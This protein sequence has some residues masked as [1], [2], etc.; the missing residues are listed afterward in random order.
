MM[1]AYQMVMPGERTRAHRHTPSALRLILDADP[2]AYTIVDGEKV[3]MLAGDVVLTPNW[4]WHSH[5]NEGRQRAYW[6]DFLDV[7]LVRLLNLMSREER[8]DDPRQRG[9]AVP[10][11]AHA[12]SMV[13]HRAPVA[14]AGCSRRRQLPRC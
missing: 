6:L 7:P 9:G 13:R 2:G 4:S 12:F 3:S 10:E 11:L 1:A 14:R 8:T 5:I